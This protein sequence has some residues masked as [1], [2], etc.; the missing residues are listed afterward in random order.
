MILPGLYHLMVLQRIFFA[1]NRSEMVW[2]LNTD[3]DGKFI[4]QPQK[5]LS[6][7]VKKS[8][9][10]SG[11]FEKVYILFAIINKEKAVT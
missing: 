4:W 3:K 9:F 7:I 6:L 8:A 5:V 2:F 1:E 11:V 10:C